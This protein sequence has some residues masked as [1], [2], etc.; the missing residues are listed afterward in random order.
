[1]KKPK[2]PITLPGDWGADEKGHN[3]FIHPDGEGMIGWLR[4]YEAA[5]PDRTWLEIQFLQ[6]NSPALTV[7][8]V[9]MTE[10]QLTKHIHK[11]LDGWFVR[12]CN[13]DGVQSHDGVV[14]SADERR[15]ATRKANAAKKGA[16]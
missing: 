3:L 15:Q 6:C 11:Y 2:L 14:L 8:F 12:R 7:G 13:L 5:E 16:S 10:D 9:Y 4:V 1:M